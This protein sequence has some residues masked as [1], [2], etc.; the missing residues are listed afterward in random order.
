MQHQKEDAA[1][2]TTRGWLNTHR[3]LAKAGGS[4]DRRPSL[5]QWFDLVNALKRN[6]ADALN[7]RKHPNTDGGKNWSHKDAKE[8]LGHL[9]T[10][11]DPALHARLFVRWLRAEI[12]TE[13]RRSEA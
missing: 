12:R 10:V 4:S 9:E 3:A 11:D 2:A 7:S 13:M 1:A 8:I 5:S 6:D